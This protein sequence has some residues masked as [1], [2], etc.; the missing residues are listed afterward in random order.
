[1]HFKLRTGFTL[2]EALISIALLCTTGTVLL[3][4]FFKNPTT[5]LAWIND[6]GHNL[7]KTYLYSIQIDTP[8]TIFT[9]LDYH[10]W[11]WEIVIQAHK[12]DPETCFQATAIRANQD[13]TR[14]LYLCN[15]E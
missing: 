11:H 14:S 13:T 9:H 3:S 12:K 15:Y 6:Y 2:V 8:D 1:M 10:G 4:F 7:S 5:E